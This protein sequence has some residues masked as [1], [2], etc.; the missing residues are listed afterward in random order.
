MDRALAFPEPV[1]KASTPETAKAQ[2]DPLFKIL[3]DE[4][5]VAKWG[6]PNKQGIELTV[7]RGPRKIDGNGVML[8]ITTIPRGARSKSLFG[9][10]DL[11]D[12]TIQADVCGRRKHGRLARYRHYR[13]ALQPA[14][15]GGRAKAPGPDLAGATT[16]ASSG[17]SPS[18]GKTTPGTR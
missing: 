4:K 11:H 5:V 3:A 18:P 2:L 9:Q 16:S 12:Y 15:D 10:T 17:A 1:E 14:V 6:W 13:P 8:K 7:E